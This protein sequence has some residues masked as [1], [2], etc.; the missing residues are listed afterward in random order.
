MDLENNDT[1]VKP[2]LSAPQDA[3]DAFDLA[4]MGH[5]QA[6][7]RKFSLWSMLAMAFCVLSSWAAISATFQ[8]G[9]DNGGPITIL[10]GMILITAVNLCIA[11]S[12]GELC[13]SMPTALGQA[14]YVYKLYSCE[15]GRLLSYLCAWTNIFGWWTASASLVAFNT[16][17]ILGLKLIYDPEWEGV[18]EPWI[19]FVVYLG[20]SLF[21]TVV[22]VVGCRKDQFL[23]WLNN[24]MGILLAAL[25][26]V[27]SL[28]FIIAVATNDHLSFRPPSFVFATWINNTGW[29]DGVV[30]FL[31]LLQS[32]YGLT[33]F[34]S[35]I[36]MVEEMPD[37]RRNGPKAIYLAVLSGAVTGFFFM[38]ICLF[39]MQDI[40][41]IID[42]P[43]GLPFIGLVQAIMGDNGAAA[44]IALYLVACIGQGVSVATTA[45]RLTWGFARDGGFPWSSYL[46][47]VDPVWKAPV[48]AIWV[49]GILTSLVGVLYLFSTT[50]L[51][52]IVSVS[53]VALMISYGIPISTLL[54][55]GRDKLCPGPFRLGK[56]GAPINYVSVAT[57]AITTVFFFFPAS[58]SPDGSNMNY[59]IAVFGVMVVVSLGFW[60]ARG[61]RTYMRTEEATQDIILAHQLGAQISR[62]NSIEKK[63]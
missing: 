6:M 21:V 54:I 48:R 12:L 59:A 49:Q 7:T 37:P 42:S 50:V 9:L 56:W 51:T 17:F 45:S 36:H 24:L 1:F 11:V 52:A 31:G 3:K 62:E 28:A 53:T 55:V 38:M 40:D 25:F 44:L 19:S 39:C 30:W 23:P 26:L 32:A 15:V 10:W 33:A 57:C 16:N 46:S 58:P 41:T 35:V 8:T 61:H 2:T 34:D 13:S 22:N 14:Y 27:F 4:G 29:S 20:F 18:N 63:E 43:T 5:E 60:L 47:K